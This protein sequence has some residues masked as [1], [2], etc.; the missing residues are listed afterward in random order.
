[1]GEESTP[2]TRRALQAF[3]TLPNHTGRTP[4]KR[5]LATAALAASLTASG[6]AAE[7]TGYVSDHSC[8]TKSAAAAKAMD[9]IQPD[10]FES[11]VKKCH[12]EGSTLV[13]VTEDNT[14]LKFDTASTAK[15]TAHQ[16]HRVRVK[17]TAADGV[18]NID[19]I[20]AIEMPKK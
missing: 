5:A 4:M 9:W 18:L 17:G 8:A 7:M 1:L 15:A 20:A 16:G 6:A 11:C 10:R 3:E 2:R 19:S 12:M 13:F 14:I